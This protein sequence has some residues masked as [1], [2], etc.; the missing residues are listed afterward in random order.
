[1]S[2]SR[3][4]MQGRF[5]RARKVTILSHFRLVCSHA[6]GNLP[7]I[8]TRIAINTVPMLRV[9]G[10]LWLMLRHLALLLSNLGFI[11]LCVQAEASRDHR[12]WLRANQIGLNCFRYLKSHE[13]PGVPETSFLEF[14]TDRI[15]Q[16]RDPGGFNDFSLFMRSTAYISQAGQVIERPWAIQ[17]TFA[18]GQS[19]NYNVYFKELL[20]GQNL[21]Q[22]AQNRK[23]NGKSS[24]TLD[25]FGSGIFS[26][27]PD[28]FSSLTGLSLM[29]DFQPK[30]PYTSISH[31]R[32]VA[33]DLFNEL[34]RSR[35]FER[36]P[37]LSVP[38]NADLIIS[39]PMG[40]LQELHRTA[41]IARVPQVVVA[42]Q[43]T[44]V[45]RF[46]WDW[47]TDDSGL[48]FVQFD[49]STP[50]ALALYEN[51]VRQIQKAGV[52]VTAFVSTDKTRGYLKI[53]K[54]PGDRQKSIPAL[55]AGP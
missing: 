25:L 10:S 55:K 1:M 2:G 23:A 14:T 49:P 41:I 9:N 12:T 19:Y 29:G 30:H 24:R 39:R 3:E 5:V 31:W 36:L 35:L 50:E 15:T 42:T 11:C 45:I 26:S 17:G 21:E 37:S 34:D 27:H 33:V 32:D 4:I 22:W 18:D 40:L 51:W 6:I 44:E 28:A 47:L 53:E 48:A 38:L 7:V 20:Q 16:L 54:H 43:Y 52:D 46:F 13:L 8:G